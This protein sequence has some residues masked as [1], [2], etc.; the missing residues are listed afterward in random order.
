MKATTLFTFFVQFVLQS[1]FLIGAFDFF[2]DFVDPVLLIGYSGGFCK[3]VFYLA[4]TLSLSLFCSGAESD[5]E[6]GGIVEGGKGTSEERSHLRRG[7]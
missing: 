7:C 1:V 4:A 3:L 2:F 6:H 5:Y